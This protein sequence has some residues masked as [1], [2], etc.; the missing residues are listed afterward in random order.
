[1]AGSG[2]R[3]KWK[4]VETEIDDSTDE[5]L[6]KHGFDPKLPVFIKEP[7]PFD[8]TK[9]PTAK[10]IKVLFMHVP[11]DSERKGRTRSCKEYLSV[12][13]QSY[14]LRQDYMHVELCFLDSPYEGKNAS[15][16]SGADTGGVTFVFGKKYNPNDYRQIWDISLTEKR[17][18]HAYKRAE[19]MVGKKYDNWFI[20]CFAFQDCLP[21]GCRRNRYTCSAAVGVIL[22]AIGIGNDYWKSRLEFDQNIMVDTLND[23]MTFAYYGQQG[24]Q[25]SPQIYSIQQG[26]LPDHMKLIK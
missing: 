24:V 21:G 22:A 11:L 3:M 2:T 20:W 23:V 5:M 14:M 8:K 7:K 10:T 1:M 15:F 4:A 18:M 17:F 25:L 6:R 12:D 9:T 16:S 19:E 26:K 13:C